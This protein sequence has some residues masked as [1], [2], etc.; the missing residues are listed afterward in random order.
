VGRR[1]RGRLRQPR[2]GPAA[3]PHWQRH[4]G[5]VPELAVLARRPDGHPGHRRRG[6]HRDQPGAPGLRAAAVPDACPGPSRPAGPPG[7][8][9]TCSTCC[10]T[11]A[12]RCCRCPTPGGASG[13]P[14]LPW[15][16][17]WSG[18]RRGIPAARPTSWP[19]A[20]LTPW[21]EWSAGRW[22]RPTTRAGAGIGSRS[23]TPAPRGLHLR[24]ETGQGRRADT[25]GS[26]LIGVWDGPAAVRQARRHRL[27]SGRPHDLTGRLRPL[28]RVDSPFSTIVRAQHAR[29]THWVHPQLVGKAA[30]TEC[31]T[32]R[33]LRHP[34]WRGLRTDK[35]PS[36][37][38][39]EN[40]LLPADRNISRAGRHAAS[41]PRSRPGACPR[42]SAAGSS[43]RQLAADGTH[44]QRPNLGSAYSHDRSS[45]PSRVMLGCDHGKH[46]FSP[47][48]TGRQ[49]ASAPP[50][51]F[52]DRPHRRHG[53]VQVFSPVTQPR[54]TNCW[55]VQR[56]LI[57]PR[58]AR[59]G[60]VF[61]ERGTWP[62]SGQIP[63]GSVGLFPA[64]LPAWPAPRP[65]TRT[66]QGARRTDPLRGCVLL[67][68]S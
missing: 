31:T 24:L 28:L 41:C 29:G 14:S 39:Q 65:A 44:S 30:F 19:P 23:R 62:S 11:T 53:R 55:P 8:S 20:W 32:D 16:L 3:V 45:G 60:T 12:S 52:V 50:S 5:D 42:R 59:A 56:V 7:P 54:R 6:D 36:Q 18:R 61:K 27:H 47:Q 13:W 58:Q 67:V 4:D 17:T 9:Y 68:P 35:K 43:C 48:T 34:S 33:V 2:P 40:R 15:T 1:P 25:L 66:S 51:I 46:L 21:K 57:P 63:R 49:R 22:P 64:C 26:L 10:T 38:H 37:V